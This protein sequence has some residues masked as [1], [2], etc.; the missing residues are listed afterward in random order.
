MNSNF[1]YQEKSS[2][3][4]SQ[5]YYDDLEYDAD[6]AEDRF[7][8]DMFR[9]RRITA[10]V[11]NAIVATGVLGVGALVTQSVNEVKSKQFN[12]V[13]SLELG[14]P[15]IRQMVEGLQVVNGIVKNDYITNK[16]NKNNV[17]DFKYFWIADNASIFLH[18]DWM[19]NVSGKPFELDSVLIDRTPGDLSFSSYNLKRYGNL[20]GDN[21]LWSDRNGEMIILKP[22]NLLYGGLKE[23]MKKSFVFKYNGGV[24][25]IPYLMIIPA[26]NSSGGVDEVKYVPLMDFNRGDYYSP[27]TGLSRT[28]N[29]EMLIAQVEKFRR[30]VGTVE[31]YSD[32]ILM[33]SAWSYCDNGEKITSSAIKAL[34]QDSVVFLNFT[35]GSC[36]GFVYDDSTVVTARHC[37]EDDEGS[38]DGNT[39]LNLVHYNNS[40]PSVVN[41]SEVQQK[42]LRHGSE[43]VGVVVF[44]SPVLS[45]IPKLDAVDFPVG[46][47][48]YDP[49]FVYSFN[50]YGKKGE[51]IPGRSLGVDWDMD[52]YLISPYFGDLSVAPLYFR[53]ISKNGTII[54]GNSGTPVVNCDGEVVSVVAYKDGRGSTVTSEIIRD[55]KSEAPFF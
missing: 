39:L 13:I 34:L 44:D 21:H 9:S 18:Y 51:V 19:N 37:L 29:D 27:V 14:D 8:R 30:L 4:D 17:D 23:I 53:A 38:T 35:G 54:K 33:N 55:L 10:F 15:T 28:S 32:E 50:A 2:L 43:D 5:E 1:D 12:E 48:Y 6:I 31:S 25:K 16:M 22:D 24:V 47:Q 52:M 45:A 20:G 49:Y 42:F 7:Y 40:K 41:T 46:Y 26:L 36:S 3:P 11:R